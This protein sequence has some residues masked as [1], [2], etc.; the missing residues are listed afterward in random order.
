MSRRLTGAMV[1]AAAVMLCAA[2]ATR[3]RDEGA[4]A[5]WGACPPQTSGT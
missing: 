1:M 3:A 5:V 4:I 2:R